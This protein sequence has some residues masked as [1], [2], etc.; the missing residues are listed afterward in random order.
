MIIG[1]VGLNHLGIQNYA[2]EY[3]NFHLN[4][5]FKSLSFQIREKEFYERFDKKNLQL[6]TDFYFKISEKYK[7]ISDKKI[8]LSVSNLN[9]LHSILTVSFDFFKILS[10]GAK[11]RSLIST[12]IE[13]TNA[14]IYISLGALNENDIDDLIKLYNDEKRIKFNYTQLSYQKENLNLNNL[15]NYA[16]KYKNKFSYGHHYINDIPILISSSI[17]NCDLFIYI[18]G[19]KKVKH[20][21]EIHAYNFKSFINLIDRINETKEL[22]GKKGRF[23]SKNNIPDQSN[24]E[25]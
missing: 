4:N 7:K 5:N 25:T 9:S 1:E 10:I 21:D 13:K 11:D 18:K 15:I 22:L 19:L 3:I 24:N 17:Y 12:L 6:P 2:E 23:F 20:P 14:D 16:S 8:G